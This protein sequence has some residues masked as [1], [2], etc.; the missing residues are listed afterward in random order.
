MGR[1]VGSFKMVA[2]PFRLAIEP[3]TAIAKFLTDVRIYTDRAWRPFNCVLCESLAACGLSRAERHAILDLHPI[4]DFFFGAMIALHAYRVR[5]LFAPRVAEALL[6]ELALQVDASAGRNDSV[7][8]NLVF[9]AFGCIRKARA[10]DNHCDHDQVIENLLERIGLHKNARTCAL[11]T[12]LAQ[13]HALA[14]PL[15][16]AAPNWW[17]SFLSLYLIR[18]ALRAERPAFRPLSRRTIEH[19]VT[20]PPRVSLHAIPRPAF[21][22]TAWLETRVARRPTTDPMR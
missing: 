15:A 21:S 1:G 20:A 6:R 19:Y 2:A 18:P 4:E 13:R 8:S 7:V 17:E 22:L 16:C 14:E 10:R 9:L 11:M 5:D 12:N 3:K